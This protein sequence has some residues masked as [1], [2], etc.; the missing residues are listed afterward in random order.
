MMAQRIKLYFKGEVNT[1]DVAVK[2]TYTSLSSIAGIILRATALKICA[3][4]NG[5]PPPLCAPFNTARLSKVFCGGSDTVPTVE[6]NS[7]IR[8][9]NNE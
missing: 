4:K 6:I 2:R 8:R 1:F 9:T 7:K 5:I 3:L